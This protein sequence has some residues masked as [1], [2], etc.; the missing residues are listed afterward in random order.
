VPV[1]YCGDGYLDEAEQ[2]DD[3]NNIDGDGCDAICMIE[4]EGGEGCTP[5][6][7]KQ[8]QHF[9]NWTA[10][11]VP[12][13]KFDA[14]FEDAFGDM[15]LLDVLR[16]GGGGLNALG[17]HTVAALLNAASAGVSYNMSVQSVIDAINEVYPGS[18]DDYEMLKNELEGF[19]QQYCPLGR[20]FMMP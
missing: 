19:N 3:G 6:Y 16:Q 17:R 7:W 8:F 18:K 13:M 20:A 2:C 11:Y 14:V 9:G 5:G 15:T 1:P 12:G 10:P 4:E